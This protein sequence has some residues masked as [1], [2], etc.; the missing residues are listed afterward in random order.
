MA[1]LGNVSGQKIFDP[2]FQ[3]PG[4]FDQEQNLILNPT[5]GSDFG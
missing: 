5:P 3:Y 2:G 1:E 4:F